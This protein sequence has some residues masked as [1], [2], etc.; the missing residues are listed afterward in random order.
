MAKK[1]KKKKKL[2]KSYNKK[3]FENV[4][5]SGCRVCTG[6]AQGPGFCYDLY[7]EKPELFLEGVYTKLVTIEDWPWTV[8]TKVGGEIMAFRN[9]S[10]ADSVNSK[11]V[12]MAAFRNIF[13]R[14]GICET[15]D[16]DACPLFEDCILA[17]RKQTGHW[18]DAPM[19]TGAPM[20]NA[21][22]NKR[23]AKRERKKA[24]KKNK[25][26]AKYICKAYPTFF[27]SDREGWKEQIEEILSDGN[28]DIK[29]DTSVE[30]S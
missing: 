24:A 8:K 30:S 19:L 22:L 4:L 27:T 9:V 11:M 13:C 2:R 15:N 21:K 10:V 18:G 12:E 3:Q 23:Q 1:G 25:K 28:K 14:S 5:C 16:Q 6:Y 20:N 17:F 7:R 29:Q 26:K